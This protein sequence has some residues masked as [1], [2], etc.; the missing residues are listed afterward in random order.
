VDLGYTDPT[1]FSLCAY[2]DHDKILYVLEAEKQ[3]GL[4]VTEV[5]QRIRAYQARYEID[6]TVIDNSNK[7]AVEEMR[8]RH[9]LALRPADKTGKSDF[10]E[11]MNGEFIQGRI[12]V[13]PQRC[14][15]LTDEY[16]G[17]IWDERS[18]KREEHPNC[19]NHVADAT[20]YAWRYCYAYLSETP[21]PRPQ[22][23]SKEWYDQEAKEMEEAEVQRYLDLQ[24]ERREAEEWGL[25]W[26]DPRSE[27]ISHRS[28]TRR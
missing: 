19:P 1:A 20:L 26:E 10:I 13:D 17:L 24:A 23:G 6:T 7:Q 14:A 25:G 12:K 2:H 5:A 11:I 28:F 15:A 8:R 18:A 16:A 9:E 27:P 22:P 21:P 3:A 4:D